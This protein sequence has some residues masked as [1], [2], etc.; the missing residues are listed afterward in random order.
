VKHRTSGI[1]HYNTD[2]D[3]CSTIFS[4]ITMVIHDSFWKFLY[5]WKQEWIL[6]WTGINSVTST[7][8]S[9]PISGKTKNSAKWPTAYCSAFCWTDCSKLSQKVVQYSICFFPCLLEN[10]LTVFWE[11]IFYIRTG[12][13]KN[14]SSN[15]IWLLLAYELKL[16]C[17]DLR[18]VTVM[19][20]LSN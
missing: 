16:N 9:L 13:I 1:L 10:L 15:S 20:S 11:K 2:Y 18:L 19:T 6:Y 14:L 5:H 7:L 3:K 17:R 4:T 8:L 12:F